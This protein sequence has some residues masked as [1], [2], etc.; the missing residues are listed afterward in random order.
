M[1]FWHINHVF[2][3]EQGI[4]KDFIQ[5]IFVRFAVYIKLEFSPKK[6]NAQKKEDK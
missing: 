4:G 1:T 3:Y 5:G 6:R 2:A